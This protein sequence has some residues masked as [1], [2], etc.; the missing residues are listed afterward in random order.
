MSGYS[1]KTLVGTTG[2]VLVIA[3][4]VGLRVL[5]MT[6]NSTPPANLPSQEKLLAQFERIP[7]GRVYVPW[8]QGYGRSRTSM[9]FTSRTTDYTMIFSCHGPGNFF[10]P[11]VLVFHPCIGSAAAWTVTQTLGKRLSVRVVAAPHTE[12]ELEIF[13]GNVAFKP[14]QPTR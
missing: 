7:A 3:I 6:S 1:K 13:A 5:T 2:L 10:V 8:T 9:S 4:L 14:V 12:W 11:N